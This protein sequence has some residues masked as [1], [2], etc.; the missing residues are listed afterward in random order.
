MRPAVALFCIIALS[1]CLPV[2][3]PEPPTPNPPTP[4][5][6]ASCGAVCARAEGMGCEWAA[7]TPKGTPCAEWCQDIQDNGILKWNLK[8]RAAAESCRAM[9]AC[10]RNPG[11]T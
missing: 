3:P 9:D 6:E 4:P 1:C 10:E 2:P 11:S 7:D 8:C 5:G